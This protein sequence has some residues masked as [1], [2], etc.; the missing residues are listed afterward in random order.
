MLST[1][2]SRRITAYKITSPST[3]S[4]TSDGGYFGSTFFNGTG[5][6]R[7]AD[8]TRGASGLLRSSLKFRIQL[9]VELFRL[10]M[11]TFRLC[12]CRQGC[13]VRRADAVGTI[14]FDFRLRLGH[15][16][17]H[18]WCDNSWRR[19]AEAGRGAVRLWITSA[20]ADPDRALSAS[21]SGLGSAGLWSFRRNRH[22]GGEISLRRRNRRRWS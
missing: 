4:L 7:S 3:R 8:V 12:P 22:A 20:D 11:L 17:A 21:A 10:G 14:V 6:A 2:P 13:E 9:P 19:C 5:P 1:L 18:R 16:R 15:Q